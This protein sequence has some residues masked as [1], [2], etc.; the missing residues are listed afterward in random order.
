MPVA[1][2]AALRFV[3]GMRLDIAAALNSRRIGGSLDLLGERVTDLS[4]AGNAAAEYVRPTDY[5][6]PHM[7]G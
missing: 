5:R 3:A 4:G 1:R 7:G 2:R 6:H